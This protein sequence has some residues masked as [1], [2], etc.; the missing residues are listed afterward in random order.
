MGSKTHTNTDTRT[1]THREDG[2]GSAASRV[3]EITSE[4]LIAPASTTESLSCH[5][6]SYQ[7][8]VPAILYQHC[9]SN[10]SRHSIPALSVT[11]LPFHINTVCLSVCLSLSLRLS[12][13]LSVCLYVCMYVRLSVNLC[14]SV[15]QWSP[16]CEPRLRPSDL[17]HRP[18][19]CRWPPPLAPQLRD[20]IK[21]T[22]REQASDRAAAAWIGS[23][24]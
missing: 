5:A 8:C 1:H 20:T 23:S 4:P 15:C 21:H 17:L 2:K 6:M 22:Y 13:C 3:S 24:T 19:Q 7:H 14:L 10:K 12:L 18:W 9:V 16:A 11:C